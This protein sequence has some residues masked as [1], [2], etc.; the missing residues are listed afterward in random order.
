MFKPGPWLHLGTNLSVSGEHEDMFT[1]RK[2][3]YN[4][5]N[6]NNN[7]NKFYGLKTRSTVTS[8][9]ATV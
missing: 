1:T 8:P 6:N 2:D 5:N 4:N 3:S 7:N 9:I